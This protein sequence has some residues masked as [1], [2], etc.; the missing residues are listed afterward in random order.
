MKKVMKQTASSILTLAL[1]ASMLA[2]FS[3][4][5]ASEL[6]SESEDIKRNCRRFLI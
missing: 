5:Y 2:P 1:T 4:V 6:K 3:N